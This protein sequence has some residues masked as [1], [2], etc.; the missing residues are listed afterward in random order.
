[1]A[2]LDW[3]VGE[4][5]EAIDAAGQRSD[6]IIFFSSDNGPWTSHG[7]LGGSAGPFRDGKGSVWEGGVR[8]PGFVY[9]PGTI[10]PRIESEPVATYDIFVTTLNLAGVPL[11]ADREFDG[12]DMMPLLLGTSVV[13][14]HKCIFYWKGCSDKQWCGV[15]SDSPLENHAT[16]GLWA[17]RCG[18]YKTHFMATEVSCDVHYMPPGIFQ[19]RPLI[20]RIDED[21][22]E[23]FPLTEADE[24]EYQVQ[25]AIATKAVKAHVASLS[26]VPNQISLGSDAAI[27]QRGGAAFCGCPDDDTCMCNPENMKAFVCTQ[28]V[29]VTTHSRSSPDSASNS[30]IPS[31]PSGEQIPQVED[32]SRPNIVVL[33]VDDS[34]YGDYS[35]YGAP[36]PDTPNVDRMAA[37]GARFTNCASGA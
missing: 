10:S 30:A 26:P 9:W 16:P 12:K 35:V 19:Q 15:P 27:Q 33:F 14:P 3:V 13:S 18:S 21:P 7:L 1:M 8:E 34:G 28:N 25:L 11:P 5:L 31:A 22:S 32:S 36:V 29:T 23:R 17:V 2:E 6:T 37:E 4:V 20:Y 24:A